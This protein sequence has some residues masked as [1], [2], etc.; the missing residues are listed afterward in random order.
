MGFWQ[1]GSFWPPLS[2]WP[3][4]SRA[5]PTTDDQGQCTSPGLPAGDYYALT[6]TSLTGGQ[7][8][9]ELY[10]GQIRVPGCNLFDGTPIGVISGSG[11]AD[12]DFELV[13]LVFADDFESGDLAS[14]SSVR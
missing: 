1:C 4:T 14:W 12:I 7:Y 2:I 10:D 13:G 6:D 5:H 11:T 8:A 9:D 3:C